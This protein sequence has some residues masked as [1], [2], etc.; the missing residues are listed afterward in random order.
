M[1][2]KVSWKP[3]KR[4]S[5]SPPSLLFHPSLGLQEI[6]LKGQPHEAKKSWLTDLQEALDQGFLF[7]K[8]LL[9]HVTS[10]A[11]TRRL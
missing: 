7:R 6:V 4:E 11:H 2:Y 3:G 5:S 9:S 1:K 8:L 10:Q